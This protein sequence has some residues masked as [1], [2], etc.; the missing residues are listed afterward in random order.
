MALLL[1]PTQNS[2]LT[3]AAVAEAAQQM[4]FFPNQQSKRIKSSSCCVERSDIRATVTALSARLSYDRQD[5]QISTYSMP[6]T[7]CPTLY[8]CSCARRFTA[9]VHGESHA[10]PI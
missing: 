7:G 5:E 6:L 1:L 4:V 8:L 3:S 10:S 2:T 9:V